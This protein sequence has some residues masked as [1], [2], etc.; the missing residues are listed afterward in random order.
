MY[1]MSFCVKRKGLSQEEYNHIWKYMD[2]IPNTDYE[3]GDQG[4]EN[5]RLTQTY[6]FG[7]IDRNRSLYRYL[8]N[9]KIKGLEWDE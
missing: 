6:V 2:R 9:Q 1:V 8:I 7:T 3:D 4:I 5:I